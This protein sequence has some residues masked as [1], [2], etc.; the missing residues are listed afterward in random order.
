M[1]DVFVTE[2]LILPV[3][4]C[5][6]YFLRCRNQYIYFVLVISV[7]KVQ[8]LLQPVVKHDTQLL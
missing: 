4:Q 5:Y 2:Y 8:V 7:R 1:Q 6:C 3:T